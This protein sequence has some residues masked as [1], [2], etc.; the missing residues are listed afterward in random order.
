MKSIFAKCPICGTEMIQGFIPLDTKCDLCGN[1]TIANYYCPN[2][3]HVCNNCGYNMMYEPLRNIC[4]N[5]K[6]RNPMEILE[7]MIDDENI[8]LMGC[9]Q[10]LVCALAVYTAYKNNGGKGVEL[11]KGLDMIK[12]R[13]A[14]VQ[15]SMC[16]L[17]GFCGIPVAMGVAYQAVSTHSDKIDEI[18]A[19]ANL[20][21]GHCMTKLM[22]P[23]NEGSKNC[24]IRNSII[25]TIESARFL[26]NNFWIDMELPQFI[27]C[28]YSDM[29]P[30]CNKEKCPFFNGKRTEKI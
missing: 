6:S 9:K 27:K 24:C 4:L 13:I 18:T 14:R 17:G 2:G 12:D 5:T 25:C 21:S 3:H 7:K 1:P 11:S 10:N 20:M 16:M 23:N 22:N 30:R 29:N 8:P 19:T 26:N 28:K 15:V